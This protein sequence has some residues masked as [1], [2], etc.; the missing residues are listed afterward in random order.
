MSEVSERRLFLKYLGA[1]FAGCVVNLA[2]PLGP[3]AEARGPMPFQ[4]GSRAVHADF[5]SFGPIV[6]SDHDDLIVP[7]GFRYQTVIAYGDRFTNSGERFGFNADFTAFIPRD[8][9]GTDGLLFVNHEYVGSPT[10][11][12]GQAF[13]AAVG[14]VPTVADYRFD[15]GASVLDIYLSAG[16]AWYVKPG[17][18]LNRRITADT[19]ASGS[20]SRPA[21]H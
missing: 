18:A 11:N 9:A 14:G 3:I 15:V 19:R 10:D 2:N 21:P 16:G 20:S 7:F 6:P 13:S 4:A 17:S 8:A 12:Y 5:L 1:G